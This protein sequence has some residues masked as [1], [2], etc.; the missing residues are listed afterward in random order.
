MKISIGKVSVERNGIEAKWD[1]MV[2]EGTVEETIESYKYMYRML[3]ELKAMLMQSVEE[4][5]GYQAEEARM[6]R[7]SHSMDMELEN[8]RFEH[9][10]FLAN[11][12]K[13]HAKFLADLNKETAEENAFKV[14]SAG[15]SD[16]EW[17]E[18]DD[19]D[20]SKDW[21]ESDD[22]LSATERALKDPDKLKAV[23]KTKRVKIK[24]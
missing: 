19:D 1:G 3:P 15:I 21:F 5:K 23:K 11:L 10:K 12:D 24:K 16:D 7:E 14:D 6:R 8:T 4:M 20:L 17:S 13:E 18:D 2:V 22:E 9:A